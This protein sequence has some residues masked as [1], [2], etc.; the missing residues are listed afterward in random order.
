MAYAVRIACLGLQAADHK[1]D[2]FSYSNNIF[3]I[4]NNYTIKERTM[5]NSRKRLQDHKCGMAY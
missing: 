5:V 3:N 1:N 4:G 2:N